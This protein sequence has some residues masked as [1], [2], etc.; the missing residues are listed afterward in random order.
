MTKHEDETKTVTAG[1][2]NRGGSPVPFTITGAPDWVRVV[3]NSGTLVANE[4]RPITFEVDSTLAFGHWSDTII[5]HTETGQNPFFM[6]GDEALPFGVRVVCRPPDWDLDAGIYP[7]T[8]NMVLKLN[9]QGEFSVD[10]EDIV[11]AYINGELRGRA[12]VMYVPQV[13]QYLAYLTIYGESAESGA[14]VSLQV[15]DA[16]ACLRYGTVLEAFTFQPDNVIGTPVAPQVIHTN[17]LVLREIPLANGWNWVSFNLAFPDPALDPALADT[18]QAS[19]RLDG[20]MAIDRP[21]GLLL[22]LDAVAFMWKRLGTRCQSE[23]EVH[24]LLQALR[25]CSRI[26]SAI[27]RR[28]SSRSIYWCSTHF[29]PWDAISQPAAFIATPVWNRTSPIST[30][31]GMGVSEKLVMAASPLRT[32]CMSPGSPPR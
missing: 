7:V 17:S 30:K 20:V 3:P 4:I 28:S 10:A 19:T 27:C 26:A 6:G 12:H 32:T 18:A 15:W 16:S 29:R 2:H 21:S 24:M 13:N 22:R 11:A 1:I 5:L 25:A 14:A 23:P 31:N 8:M 9:I